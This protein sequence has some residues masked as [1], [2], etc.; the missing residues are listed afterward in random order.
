MSYKDKLDEF[1]RDWDRHKRWLKV[2]NAKGQPNR[3]VTKEA[4]SGFSVALE[5]MPHNVRQRVLITAEKTIGLLVTWAHAKER[6][7]A[8]A[9]A[10]DEARS[11]LVNLGYHPTQSAPP[12][13]PPE[14]MPP[15]PSVDVARLGAALEGIGDSFGEEP[16]GDSE[17]P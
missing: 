5:D 17:D 3:Y 7:E 6:E 2:Q 16:V 4:T 9:R 15:D 8:V 10:V 13:R 12:S 14:P 11:T 1:D